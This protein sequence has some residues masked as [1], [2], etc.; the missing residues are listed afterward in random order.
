M[1]GHGPSCSEKVNIGLGPITIAMLSA[2]NFIFLI[3]LLSATWVANKERI[4]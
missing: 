2:A 3:T 1:C 4:R